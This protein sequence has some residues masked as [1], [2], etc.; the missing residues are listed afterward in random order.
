MPSS[1]QNQPINQNSTKKP[2]FLFGMTLTTYNQNMLKNAE[3]NQIFFRAHT[4]MDAFLKF[5]D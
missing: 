4:V 2:A 5:K 1:K 3:G